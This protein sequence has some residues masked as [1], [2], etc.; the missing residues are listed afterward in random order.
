MDPNAANYKNLCV[1]CSF[2]FVKQNKT[3]YIK[4]EKKITEV[5][6]IYFFLKSDKQK[7]HKKNI[8]YYRQLV[9]Q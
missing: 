4:M 6:I 2:T 5:C 3:K 1:H 9:P 7:K 8:V